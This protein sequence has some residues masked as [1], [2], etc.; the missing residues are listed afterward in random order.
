MSNDKDENTS[1]SALVSLND[2]SA[3]GIIH[4]LF[5]PSAKEIGSFWGEKVKKLLSEKK[6][7]NLETHL[8]AVDKTNPQLA[9][10]FTARRADYIQEWTQY[11]DKVEEND[12]D[13][14]MWQSVLED[15]LV[16]GGE[17]EDIDL[18]KKMTPEMLEIIRDLHALKSRLKFKRI[19]N[20]KNQSLNKLV[21]L[22]LARK[23]TTPRFSSTFIILAFFLF[24]QFVSP[25]LSEKLNSLFEFQNSLSSKNYFLFVAFIFLV[26]A[27]IAPILFIALGQLLNSLQKLVLVQHS[28]FTQKGQGLARKMSKYWPV[29]HSFIKAESVR[30]APDSE[31]SEKAE[32]L[33]KPEVQAGDEESTVQELASNSQSDTSIKSNNSIDTVSWRWALFASGAWTGAFIFIYFFTTVLLSLQTNVLIF[34]TFLWVSV[35]AETLIKFMENTVKHPR[36]SIIALPFALLI[37]VTVFMLFLTGVTLAGV[38]VQSAALQQSWG[39]FHGPSVLIC[40]DIGVCETIGPDFAGMVRNWIDTISAWKFSLPLLSL[41]VLRAYVYKIAAR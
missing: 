30:E 25:I 29:E 2:S 27:A 36:V 32:S 11:A 15:I 34:F 14:A 13:A 33:I 38:D 39:S 6:L 23:I 19:S 37:G 35:I 1:D 17:R 5:H 41:I 28:L 12:I 3:K 40:D 18:A 9:F 21:E 4:D 24:L 22:G 7:K 10:E 20:S 16:N 31:A 8:N 26:V